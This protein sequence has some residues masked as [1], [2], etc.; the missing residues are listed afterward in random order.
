MSNYIE[1]EE[2]ARVRRA[3]NA[4]ARETE[5]EDEEPTLDG[6]PPI[7]SLLPTG[8]DVTIYV[9]ADA[10]KGRYSYRLLDSSTGLSHCCV[11]VL[12]EAGTTALSLLAVRNSLASILKSRATE[13]ITSRYGFSCKSA[14]LASRRRLQVEIIVTEPYLADLGALITAPENEDT[15]DSLPL[16]EHDR[17]VW[18]AVLEQ[19]KRF[20]TTWSHIA[21][22]DS[23]I[24][25]IDAWADAT[26][27]SAAHGG[28]IF[29]FRRNYALP[30]GAA[31]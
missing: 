18:S 10:E 9:H 20:D 17:R 7:A 2:D 5:P 30:I 16:N 28:P 1:N 11:R 3:V 13:L 21:A 25:A 29:S 14:A 15:F 8:P 4:A 31:E 23:T 6:P 26:L 12:K 19:T 24:V 27:A 22:H